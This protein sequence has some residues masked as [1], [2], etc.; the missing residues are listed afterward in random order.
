MDLV[1]FADILCVHHR[2]ISGANLIGGV[3]TVLLSRTTVKDK[4]TTGGVFQTENRLPG[5]RFQPAIHQIDV[6][7][8][9]PQH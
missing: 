3:T 5:P 6:P 8:T 9:F 7:P 1:R 4:R 2:A